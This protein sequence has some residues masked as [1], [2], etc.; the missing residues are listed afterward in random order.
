MGLGLPDPWVQHSQCTSYESG[1]RNCS[2]TSPLRPESLYLNNSDL[3]IVFCANVT[4]HWTNFNFSNL[5]PPLDH[6]VNPAPVVGIT[7]T[8]TRLGK[9]LQH[10][11]SGG[12][13]RHSRTTNAR[14]PRQ[15]PVRTFSHLLLRAK[16][17]VSASRLPVGASARRDNPS[18]R[19]LSGHLSKYSHPETREMTLH[20]FSERR[21]SCT[22]RFKSSTGSFV[23]QSATARS[24][25][26][27]RQ[28]LTWL[29]IPST[30]GRRTQRPQLPQRSA[31]I[32][33]LPTAPIPS[34]VTTT[35]RPAPVGVLPASLLTLSRPTTTVT[36][37]SSHRWSRKT[38]QLFRGSGSASTVMSAQNSLSQRAITLRVAAKM[39]Q[40]FCDGVL[41]PTRRGT[42]ATRMPN[43]ATHRGRS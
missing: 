37:L 32:F 22:G 10:H 3:S 39:S 43:A 35:P 16:K 9:P 8:R 18:E 6:E 23:K 33:F 17:M 27:V 30:A 26:S 2:C 5:V 19:S 31:E 29:H 21:I 4:L 7:Q 11:R 12:V 24:T 34:S 15:D 20:L 36:T 1:E 14:I 41:Q 40:G 25:S 13:A 42:T 28:R 38:P